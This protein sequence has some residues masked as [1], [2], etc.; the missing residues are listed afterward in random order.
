MKLDADIEIATETLA[1]YAKLKQRHEATR[2]DFV[3]TELD[4]AITYWEI[5]DSPDSTTSKAER[6]L[7]NARQAY[8]SAIR[9]L[10]DAKLPRD[11]RQQ[12]EEKIQRLAP[13]LQRGP[14]SDL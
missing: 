7:E 11:Q 9:A 5:A 14:G 2:F 3:L 13:M 12:V 10:K 6:N 4:L 1:N 8:D